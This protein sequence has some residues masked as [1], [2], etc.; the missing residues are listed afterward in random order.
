MTNSHF[1]LVWKLVKDKN[2][3]FT[4]LFLYELCS[5][6]NQETDDGTFFFMENPS[7]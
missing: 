4:L 7:W 2:Q 5:Q 1:L 6:G 3:S